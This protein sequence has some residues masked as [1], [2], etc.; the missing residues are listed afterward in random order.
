MPAFP[1]SQSIAAGATFNPMDG[2]NFEIPE[3]NGVLKLTHRATAVGLVATISAQ[4]RQLVQEAPV[5]A[6]GTAGQ[7]PTD[8]QV[9][10]IIEGVRK[11]ER[12]T[13]RYRN[14]TAGAITVDGFVD[15]TPARGG[16]F[17][18]RR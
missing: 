2:A 13:A 8:F 17:G 18:K 11:G 10:P 16:M 15:Y 14:P 5:P 7:T 6:G 12:I 1:F 4:S 9:P 3:T